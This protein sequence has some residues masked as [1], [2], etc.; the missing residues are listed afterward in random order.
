MKASIQCQFAE[1]AT[2]QPRCP[3]TATRKWGDHWFCDVHGERRH[4]GKPTEV[5]PMR[6]ACEWICPKCGQM[7][8]DELAVETHEC[9]D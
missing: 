9:P 4:K 8:T 2:D 1:S 3:R 6:V 7:E 5:E